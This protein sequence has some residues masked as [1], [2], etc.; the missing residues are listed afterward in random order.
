MLESQAEHTKKNILSICL[1]V[2][3]SHTFMVSDVFSL[4]LEFVCSLSPDNPTISLF[5][6]SNRQYFDVAKIISIYLFVS[7]L[8]LLQFRTFIHVN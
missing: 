6:H 5:F 3:E 8:I 1:L 7:C 4:M 2:R